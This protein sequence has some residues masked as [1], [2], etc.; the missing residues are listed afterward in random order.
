MRS[1]II[2]LCWY[3]P[4]QPQTGCTK[5]T[6]IVIDGFYKVTDPMNIS[7]Q[8]T[9]IGDSVRWYARNQPRTFVWYLVNSIKMCLLHTGTDLSLLVEELKCFSFCLSM[10]KNVFH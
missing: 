9:S 7:V 10:F 4:S 6:Y 5:N 2:T 1:D 8:Y 3:L